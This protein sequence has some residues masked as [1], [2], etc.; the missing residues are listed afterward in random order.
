MQ[1]THTTGSGDWSTWKTL[2]VV[3]IIVASPV[4]LGLLLRVFDRRRD[5][6]ATDGS[7]QC[8]RKAEALKWVGRRHPG[9]KVLEYVLLASALLLM[10]A[11]LGGPAVVLALLGAVIAAYRS[12]LAT[13]L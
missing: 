7:G 4:V 5:A 1:F 9:W 3:A 11:D 10:V 6:V 8:P 2:L 13:R 12:G